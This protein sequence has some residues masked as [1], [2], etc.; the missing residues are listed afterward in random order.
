MLTDIFSGLLEIPGGVD[1]I[2]LQEVDP[3][4]ALDASPDGQSPM[5]LRRRQSVH[6]IS[7]LRGAVLAVRPS[8][9]RGL[10]PGP[11]AET[12]P[13]AARNDVHESAPSA[14]NQTMNTFPASAAQLADG[15]AAASWLLLDGKADTPKDF[16][17]AYELACRGARLNSAHCKGALARCLLSG[18]GVAKDAVEG[19]RLARES[20]ACGSCYGHFVLGVAH[21]SGEGGAQQDDAEAVS[22]WK[23]AA[24][25]GLASAQYNLGT[26]CGAGQG[27]ALDNREAIRLYGLAA[28]QGYSSAYY[29]LGYVTENGLGVPA[30]ASQAIEWYQL[31]C[32]QDDGDFYDQAREAVKRLNYSS[33]YTLSPDQRRVLHVSTAVPP[34]QADDARPVVLNAVGAEVVRAAVLVCC[35]AA[36]RAVGFC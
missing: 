17:K 25:D 23:I 16:V 9:S 11:S 22:H 35:A 21:L 33:G 13:S 20:A 34:S 26:M 27:T 28:A 18:R 2:V 12:T 30:D 32:L 6:R 29:S 8:L 4:V 15:D 24:D 31:A 5:S 3:S 19:L 7:S 14:S 36:R 10:R 1:M